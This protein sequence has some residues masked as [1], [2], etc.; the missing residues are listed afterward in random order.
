MVRKQPG[1]SADERRA[2][3]T[4]LDR[5]LGALE[6]S[7]EPADR[8]LRHDLAHLADALRESAEPRPD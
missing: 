3:A 7:D 6:A 4:D 8:V 2:L 5:V 1:L